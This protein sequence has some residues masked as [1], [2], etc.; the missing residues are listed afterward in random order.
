MCN[1]NN[2]SDMASEEKYLLFTQENYA[3]MKMIKIF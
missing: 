2:T 3:C 1:V